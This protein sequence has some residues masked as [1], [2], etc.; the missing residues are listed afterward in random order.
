MSH[1]DFVIPSS[2]VLPPRSA[3]M[4]RRSLLAAAF[5][6]VLLATSQAQAFWGCGGFGTN[7]YGYGLPA[8]WYTGVDNRIPP[9]FALHPPVY[10]SGEIVRIPYGA[11][12]FAYPWG[13]P[14]F[15]PPAI[16]P[17]GPVEVRATHSAFLAEQS[18]PAE[19]V[20]IENEF[21][22]AAEGPLPAPQANEPPAERQTRSG[23]LMIRNPHYRPD[24]QVA[25]R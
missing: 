13:T 3:T 23:G 1:L 21:F 4:M 16:T 22:D 14:F 11:S 15:A 25:G 12:P 24:A 7:Y 10:Y 6:M 20:L 8:G 9:Y 5:A 2:L 18:P 17:I 19:P